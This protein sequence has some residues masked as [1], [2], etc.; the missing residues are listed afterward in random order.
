MTAERY[1]TVFTGSLSTK[2]PGEYPYLI[3]DPNPRGIGA[4]SALRRGR[5]PGERL[6]REIPFSELPAGCRGLVLD[7]YREIWGY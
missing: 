4:G 1:T 7:V 3:M 6:R 5:P 2:E